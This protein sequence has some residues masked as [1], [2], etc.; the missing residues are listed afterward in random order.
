MYPTYD[1]VSA[2][3]AYL[4][5]DGKC[6]DAMIV[7]GMVF[8]MD[9]YDMA[10]RTITYGNKKHWKQ[11]TVSTSDRYDLGF[12]DAVVEQEEMTSYRRDLVYVE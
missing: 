11:I 9:E 7:D 8:T 10:G 4:R 2:Y 6:H 5:A 1:D 3:Q 12:S